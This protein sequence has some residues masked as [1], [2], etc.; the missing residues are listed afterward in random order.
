MKKLYYQITN[1]K[2]IQVLESI[3]VSQKAINQYQ[4]YVKGNNEESM[5]LLSKK[6]RRNFMCG[7]RNKSTVEY[8]NLRINFKEYKDTDTVEI[9]SIY[10]I[11][12]KPSKF[13]INNKLKQKIDKLI[14]LD[15]F[16]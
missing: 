4:T 5:R 3:E 2:L 11:K 8:G 7:K 10:N 13:N 14:E 1:K 6:L 15:L 9:I 16:D 12:G